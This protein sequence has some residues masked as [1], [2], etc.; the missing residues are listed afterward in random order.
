M[1]CQATAFAARSGGRGIRTPERCDPPAVFKTVS[2]CLPGYLQETPARGVRG[3]EGSGWQDSNLR[4]L[5]PKRNALPTC[6]TPRS[7]PRDWVEVL[8]GLEP[9]SS[10][11]A[12]RWL[13]L[14]THSTTAHGPNHLGRAGA[15]GRTRTFNLLIRSQARCPLRHESITSR[16]SPGFPTLPS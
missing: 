5:R 6:A 9:A 7:T 3:P 14:F 12:G 8:A 2:S 15:L 13:G 11:F 4:P 16:L 10:C 1:P